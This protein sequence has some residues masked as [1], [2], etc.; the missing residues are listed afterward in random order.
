MCEG[1]YIYLSPMS[2][3]AVIIDLGINRLTQ[4]VITFN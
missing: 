4:F 2:R 1:G 3:G